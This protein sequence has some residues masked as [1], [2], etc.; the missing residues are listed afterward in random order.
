M[1]GPI[2]VDE[3]TARA[4]VDFPVNPGTN[5]EAAL[6]FLAANPDYAW[7][8]KEIADRTSVPSSSITKTAARLH[9]KGLVDRSSGYYFVPP[10]RLDE[11]RGV[12]G[13]LQQLTTMAG[14]PGQTPVHPTGRT[15]REGDGPEAPASADE[16]DVIVHEV[17]DSPPGEPGE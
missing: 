5:E 4:A 6:R 13:D 11:I 8:P 1:T 16:I 12:L 3:L 10:A 15:D 9:E 14:E 7:P 17:V 2:P